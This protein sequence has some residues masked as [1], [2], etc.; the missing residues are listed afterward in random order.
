MGG[1]LS[2]LLAFSPETYKSY[3]KETGADEQ[4]SLLVGLKKY[5]KTSGHSWHVLPA[6][7]QI[8][9]CASLPQKRNNLILM[10]VLKAILFA[11]RTLKPNTAIDSMF[12]FSTLVSA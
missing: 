12:A 10:S 4:V 11:S 5:T 7:L 6:F 1:R 9:L 8:K 2:S 3:L